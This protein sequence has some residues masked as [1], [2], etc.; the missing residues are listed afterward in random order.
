MLINSNQL[1]GAGSVNIPANTTAGVNPHNTRVFDFWNIK[2][3]S[4]ALKINPGDLTRLEIPLDFRL[5]GTG[6]LCCVFVYRVLQNR[7][8]VVEKKETT[9]LGIPYKRNIILY[10]DSS[11]QVAMSH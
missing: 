3:M 11:L 7:T 1:A 5:L 2:L 4:K 8:D 9:M 10:S 6:I